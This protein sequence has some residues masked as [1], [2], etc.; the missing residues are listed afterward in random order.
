MGKPRLLH[1]LAGILILKNDRSQYLSN[2]NAQQK[3]QASRG[4]SEPRSY[5]CDVS[6]LLMIVKTGKKS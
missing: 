1:N 2:Y 3:I 5:N 6:N 4:S